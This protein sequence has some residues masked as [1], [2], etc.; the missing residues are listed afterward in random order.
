MTI[1]E[2]RRRTGEERPG[3]PEQGR[4]LTQAAGW[5]RCLVLIVRNADIGRWVAG[6][7]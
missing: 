1:A 4:A 2:Y 5:G 3:K 6:Q 7:A